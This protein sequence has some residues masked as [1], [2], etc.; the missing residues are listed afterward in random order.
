MKQ[1]V[2]ALALHNS[3]ISVIEKSEELKKRTGAKVVY[4]HAV[5][6]PFFNFTSSSLKEKD[7]AN[8]KEELIAKVKQVSGASTADVV[9]SFKGAWELILK[10]TEDYKADLVVLG[11]MSNDRSV[12]YLG[13]TAKKVLEKIGIPVFIARDKPL[14]RKILIPTD[15]GD[16]TMKAD[17]VKKFL[18]SKAD[19]TYVYANTVAFGVTV[20]YTTLAVHSLE[21]VQE[22][23]KEQIAEF[24]KVRKDANVEV[25]EIESN[26]SETIKDYAENNGFSLTVLASRN[27]AGLSPII[28]GSTASKIA[29]VV[30]TNLL[31]TFVKD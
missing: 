29:Q 23:I 24:K 3:D 19:A 8:I 30:N 7:E 18:N 17:D 12:L 20:P 27:L 4:V 11:N 1:I 31:I 2:A 16:Y 5:D 15:L 14:D 28:F 9:V 26:I 6:T 25:L 13:S 21:F 10:T 22:E